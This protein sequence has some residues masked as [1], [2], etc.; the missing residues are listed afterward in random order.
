MKKIK[1][2]Q[3]KSFIPI[4]MW[5][6]RGKDKISYPKEWMKIGWW[7]EQVDYFN[8]IFPGLVKVVWKEPNFP[9]PDMFAIYDAKIKLKDESK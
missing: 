2:S 8:I 3:V 1:P 6:S 5:D 7:V 4:Y 9:Y